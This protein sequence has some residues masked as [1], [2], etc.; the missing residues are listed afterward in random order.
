MKTLPSLKW[1][2]SC[3]LHDMEHLTGSLPTVLVVDDDEDLLVI[4]QSTLLA[5]G[6][7]PIFSPNG[8]NVLH[9]IQSRHP[10]LVLMDIRMKGRDGGAI[11]KEIKANPEL[12]S[13]PVILFSAN[14]NIEQVSRDCGADGFVLK[15]FEGT[16]FRRIL[17]RV[18]ARN[19]QY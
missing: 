17:K 9:I 19:N 4:L 13:T 7:N 16:Q 14:A 1:Q 8:F 18:M 10:D 3:I 11:C 2:H 12:A 6:Y 15:P 5:E